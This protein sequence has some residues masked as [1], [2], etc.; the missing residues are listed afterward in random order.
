M[1]LAPLAVMGIASAA[2]SIGSALIGSHATT[3]AANTQAASQQAALDFEKQ[4]LAQKQAQLV[5]YETLGQEG[6]GQLAGLLGLQAPAFVNPAQ[7]T[8]AVA[9]PGTTGAAVPRTPPPTPTYGMAT[10][11]PTDVL[12]PSSVSY[13]SPYGGS[14]NVGGN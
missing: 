2:G 10:L 3:S 5:P 7:P 14:A 4:Q 13:V 1:P 12:P 6:G 11:A 8:G 9:R